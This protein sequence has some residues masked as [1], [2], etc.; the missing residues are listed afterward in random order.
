MN[1]RVSN[2]PPA[3]VIEGR[4]QWTPTTA[5]RDRDDPWVVGVVAPVGLPAQVRTRS[6]AFDATFTP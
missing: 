1:E 3:V 5:A 2:G 6:A 4:V